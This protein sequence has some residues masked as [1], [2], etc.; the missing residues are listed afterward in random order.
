MAEAPKKFDM[1]DAIPIGS[2]AP[3]TFDMSDA[4]P[5]ENDFTANE[6]GEGTY[7]MAGPDGKK[8]VKIPYSMISTASQAGYKMTDADRA[9]Y[10]KD[11]G[12]DTTLNEGTNNPKG[13]TIVGK[14]SAGQPIYG[15][16]GQGSALGQFADAE[17][18]AVGGA[19]KGVARSLWP[20]PTEEEKQ[21]GLTTPYDTIMRYPERLAQPNVDMMQQA[22]E[23]AKAGHTS[24]AI[25]HGV[26]SVIPVIGPWAAQVG[27]Q[28]GQQV[29]AGNYAGALGTV[30]GNAMVAEA[31]KVIGE[32]VTKTVAGIRNAEPLRSTA[33]A[34]T[35]TSPRELR[36]LAEEAHAK[37]VKA[38]Q[39]HLEVSQKA[40]ETTRGK[41]LAHGAEERQANEAAH[42]EHQEKVATVKAKNRQVMEKHNKE[43][44]D[45]QEH[46]K[47]VKEKHEQATKQVELEN[48][49]AEHALELRRQGEQQLE[50]D[51]AAYYA[52]EDAVKARVKADTDTKWNPVHSKLDA[53][54]IDGGAIRTPLDAIIDISPEV[55]R[56]VRQLIPDP[57]DADPAS[58]YAQKRAEILK[59]LGHPEDAYSKMDD[60]NRANIDRAVAAEGFTPDPIDLD[61]QDGVGVPFDK[62]HR[63]QSI[64]GRNIRNG[65]YGYEGPLLGEMK[66]LQKVLHQAE[67]QIAANNGM[68]ADLSAARQATREYHEAFG[69]ERNTPK[70][71]PDVRKQQANPEQFKE[72]NDQDRLDAAKKHD[73]SLVTDFEKVKSQRDQL[74]KM[75]TED[76]LRKS[77]KQAPKPPTVGDLR[78][79]YNLKPPPDAPVMTRRDA[80][81]NLYQ[82]KNGN[83]I[84]GDETGIKH[85]LTIE[86]SEPVLTV[87]D[88]DGQ[89]YRL[90]DEKW[91]L[92]PQPR[93]QELTSLTA[94]SD[95]P[96]R[97]EQPNRPVDEK[98]D[99]LADRAKKIQEAAEYQ[100]KHG[101]AR[102]VNALYYTVPSAIMA[103]F[104][105]E[106]GHIGW[107]LGEAS[108]PL[109]ILG[110]SQKIVGLLDKPSVVNWI[111]KVTAKDVIE[112]QKL[113]PE[114]QALFKDDLRIL[115]TAAKKKGIKVSPAMSAFIGGA[116]ASQQ[117]KPKIED[118][119]VV[120]ADPSRGVK[121]V[122]L[123]VVK[124]TPKELLEQSKVLQES[125]RNSG[126]AR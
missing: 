21:R 43:V 108:A 32:G 58:P 116:A 44:S 27:E 55:A 1:K 100:R 23:D 120:E 104:L 59:A 56:E 123:P 112:F 26:A 113:P 83:W 7:E 24:E 86:P 125:F 63:A 119:E 52:K 31:P 121:S 15:P 33:K 74:K 92:I 114:Q 64:I 122:T 66:Q 17:L 67:S 118:E 90:R 49:G 88:A 109:A 18:G 105:A 106:S 39:D 6:K 3:A 45:V 30:V 46:N 124:N 4:V 19:I 98:V 91:E 93:P 57:E 8:K 97:A 75:K 53:Q 65:K 80:Q 79:G 78:E 28:L 102:A 50:A 69:R 73:P 34:M 95:R 54:T 87:K 62:I 16:K 29:G 84:A 13:S 25:G 9:R 41:E 117:Q 71:Q 89:M 22:E 40:A 103:L 10:V 60:F 77:L 81:G 82:L 72:D 70:N 14:N 38:A 115:A 99:L 61:P 110:M 12:A 96:D 11:A 36:K 47:K 42:A 2:Q 35:N 37:N 20:V 85:Q 48:S 51:T 5:I 111:S 76:Q 101:I 107:A 94:D 126:F 68:T